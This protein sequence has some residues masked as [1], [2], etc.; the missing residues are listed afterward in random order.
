MTY[1]SRKQLI[2]I[3]GVDE[4]FLV[5]L[6]SEDIVDRDAP[7]GEGEF[8]ERMLERA[9]VASNLVLELDVNLA[10]AAIIV[11]MREEMGE[12]RRQMGRLLEEFARS[13]GGGDE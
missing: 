5:S 11:R 1:Y 7:P 8:S 3:L 2:E 6:E 10:G 9:R 4:G 12:L 13:Q